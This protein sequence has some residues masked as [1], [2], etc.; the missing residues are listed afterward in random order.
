MYR[1]SRNAMSPGVLVA[2]AGQAVVYRS[3]AIAV[4]RK[5]LNRL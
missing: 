5:L 1:Y 2:I 4:Y 3:P